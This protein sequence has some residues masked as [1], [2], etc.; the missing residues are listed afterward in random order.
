MWKENIDIWVEQMLIKRVH[1]YEY[2]AH[3][4]VCAFGPSY[5]ILSNL[6]N[7]YNFV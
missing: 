1:I 7:T 3:L 2:T 4:L 6:S 5:I